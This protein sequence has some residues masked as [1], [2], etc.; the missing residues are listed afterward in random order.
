MENFDTGNA[1]PTEKTTV[2]KKH[3]ILYLLMIPLVLVIDGI[4]LTL[5][6]LV[7]SSLF[8]GSE[9]IGHG[10]PAVTIICFFLLL[11]VTAAIIIL[12]VALTIVNSR[13]KHRQNKN[14]QF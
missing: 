5:A 6:M 7:D 4:F 14:Q 9:V 12:S 11:I 8:Q 1:N 13:K 2:L 10:M 3:P